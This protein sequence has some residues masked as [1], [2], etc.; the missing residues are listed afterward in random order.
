MAGMSRLALWAELSGISVVEPLL[1]S[2]YELE[3]QRLW[4]EEQAAPH[5]DPWFS[6]FH[7]SQF[8][9]TDPYACGRALVYGLMGLPDPEPIAPRLR[10]WFDV[11]SNL[12]HDWVRRFASSG[13]LL[14]KSPAVGDAFQTNFADREHWLTGASDAIVLPPFW[15]K[16]HCVEV[17]TT[18]LPG[19]TL[20]AVADGRNAVSLRT[21]A[22]EGRDV[23]VYA[24]DNGQTV[25]RTMRNIHL[26]RRQAS[27]LR[28]NLDDGSHLR[29]TPDHRLML[30]DGTY[31]RADE[32]VPGV[33]LM[34]FDSRLAKPGNDKNLRRQVW[35]GPRGALRNGNRGG[36][37]RWQYKWSGERLFDGYSYARSNGMVVDHKDG[38]PLNDRYS[39]LQLVT[40]SEHGLKHWATDD[41]RA[42]RSV[43]FSQ[44]WASLTD[45]ERAM[46]GAKA[47][48]TR[49]QEATNQTMRDTYARLGSEW[50]SERARKAWETR[51]S[52]Q[53]T[54][55]NHCVISIEPAGVEDT[56]CGTVGSVGN[57]AVVTSGDDPIHSD[58]S[59]I[60]VSNSHEKV[61]AMLQDREQTPASHEKYI[62]QV[63]TYIGLSHEAPFTPT[64]T[65]CRQSWAIM[66]E[67][68]EGSP[69]R[70][71]PVHE[72]L[73]CDSQT[74]TLDPPDDGTLIYS[75]REEPLTTV[76]YYFSLDEEHMTVGRERL[77]EFRDAFLAGTIPQ[78]PREGDRA[79]WS[80][81]QCKYC[82]LKKP[83]K[84]DYQ[85]KITKLADS[86]HIEAATKIRPN[87]SY[88]TMRAAVLRR[89][90]VEQ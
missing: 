25:V 80:I 85:T 2:A 76:S 47:A 29:C 64:V 38:N 37:W 34:R 27:L 78:H 18:C 68:V 69:I 21:L 54:P 40:R 87:Y 23:D 41:A 16:G 3:E 82:A 6:S 22:Q 62:R 59:G 19:D 10:A 71:C 28:I 14:S 66:R 79:M 13:V 89:W 88:E 51:R 45:N 48:A 8:P 84:A 15:R 53:R 86:N 17:K 81:G 32:L 36:R 30:L 5:G 24:S 12:E 9:G 44:Y 70:W 26:T 20:V 90:G 7:A 77:A 1:L 55:V 46:H 49:D 33:S 61:I 31:R 83:C 4:R 11:G 39:N 50:R 72:T 63:N 42:E 35:L 52:R 57:F 60:I 73:D 65:V 43:A 75:S 56:Y 74:L 58:L 67:I